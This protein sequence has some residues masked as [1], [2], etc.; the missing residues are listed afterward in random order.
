MHIISTTVCPDSNGKFGKMRELVRKLPKPLT[1]TKATWNLCIPFS[2]FIKAD[3]LGVV[4]Y[5]LCEVDSF[6][7]VHDCAILIEICAWM[8]YALFHAFSAIV[9]VLIQL[10][11]IHANSIC[12]TSQW[13]L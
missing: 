9:K 7:T 8:F 3:C 2:T 12:W 4:T 10:I 1:V 13:C 11:R 5:M 6:E